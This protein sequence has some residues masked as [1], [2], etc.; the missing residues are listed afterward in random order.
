MKPQYS[1]HIKPRS[2]TS[3]FCLPVA[4]L[5][6]ISAAAAAEPLTR[7]NIGETEN[8][9]ARQADVLK[10]M[11]SLYWEWYNNLPPARWHDPER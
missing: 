1:H 8:L 11:E 3:I 9:A 6:G 5:C 10:K 7:P 4:A 2:L